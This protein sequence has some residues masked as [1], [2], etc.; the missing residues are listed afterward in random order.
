MAPQ[1]DAKY[2]PKHFF[3]NDVFFGPGSDLI[4]DLISRAGI[5][6][7]DDRD[8]QRKDLATDYTSMKLKEDEIPDE[9]QPLQSI[10]T[11]FIANGVGPD[12]NPKGKKV[13]SQE[14]CVPVTH[15]QVPHPE[16]FLKFTMYNLSNPGIDYRSGMLGSLC[17]IRTFKSWV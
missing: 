4:N 15:T 11:N 8:V 2:D 10:Y 17:W 5:K 13:S 9:A 16:V 12:K 6:P 14:W 7:L 1:T 3:A